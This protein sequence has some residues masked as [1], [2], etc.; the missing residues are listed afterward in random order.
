MIRFAKAV[1]EDAKKLTEVQ[2]KTFD[3]DARRFL[4]DPVA[5]LPVTIQLHGKR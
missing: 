1:D 2:I 3:D 5:V 4:A